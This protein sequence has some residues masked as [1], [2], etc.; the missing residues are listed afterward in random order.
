MACGHII[1]AVIGAGVLSLPH[2][3][4]ALGW[5]AGVL[6]LVAFFAVT[7]WCSLMLSEMHEYD[8]VRHGTYGDAVVNILGP[9]S[10]AAVTVCQVLNLV[11]SAIGYT[12]AAG[13]SLRMVEARGRACDDDPSGGASSCG[14]PVWLMS[15]AFGAL[16]LVLSQVPTLEAAWWSSMVGAA[17]SFLYATAAFGMGAARGA[18]GWIGCVCVGVG[19][20]GGGGGGDAGRGGR[21]AR[22][23]DANNPPNCPTNTLPLLLLLNKQTNKQTADPSRMSL[24]GRADPPLV[25]SMSVFNALGAIAFAYSFSAVLLEVQDTLHEPPSATRTMK[26]AVHASL[27]VTF[28]AYIGV[29]VTGYAALGD[30][31]PGNILTGFSRPAALVTAAN[32]CVLVHM[33][34]VG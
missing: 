1:C 27:A 29:G 3:M 12:V 32:A 16:Q 28:A 9:G 10:A 4:A 23:A 8:G 31:T 33:V 30:D 11:L 25:K 34:G 6:S 18:W 15:A 22:G 21:R 5:A 17:M 2:A 24:L 14:T 20:L 19:L 26:K 13:E 7:L